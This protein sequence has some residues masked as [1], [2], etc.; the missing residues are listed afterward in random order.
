MDVRS[1]H[2]L[3]R[4]F[5]EV[6]KKMADSERFFTGR[7]AT[8][9]T[10]AAERYPSDQTVIQMAA[11]LAKRAQ[12][13]G[14]HLISRAELRDVYNKLHTTNTK[15]ASFLQDELGVNPNN[16]PEAKKM[17]RNAN[18]GESVRQEDFADPKLVA[19][20]ESAF[21]KNVG[22]K[23]GYDPR[24]GKVAEK[25]VVASLPGKPRVQVVDGR[26]YAVLCQASYD[27]P[28]GLATVLIPVEVVKSQPVP[29]NVFLSRAGFVNLN[30]ENL[31]QHLVS[32][33]GKYF[34]VNSAQLFDV[35]K[36]AKFGATEEL[37]SVDRAVLALKAKAGTPAT[38]DPNGILYQEVDKYR[39]MVKVPEH[40]D[41]PKFAERL[42]STAGE[43]EFVFGKQAVDTGRGMVQM[44][45]A[46]IGYRNAQIKVSNFNDDSIIYSVA[47]N[48]AGFKVPVKVVKQ[49]SGKYGV[50]IP[51][52][53]MAAGSVETLDNTGVKTAL[54][55][56]DQ[57]AFA[58]AVGLDLASSQQLL[59]E[60]E[61]ACDV[62][63]YKRA[64]EVVSILNDRGDETAFKYAFNLYMQALDGKQVKT[65]SAQPKMKT[66]KIG[67][68][69]VEAS[70]GL[71]V[72]KVYVDENGVVQP[73]YRKN[74]NKTD[75]VASGGFMHSKIIMGM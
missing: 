47:I 37:D 59:G 70:T 42:S 30:K 16:L 24:V 73:K 58:A 2:N 35:S 51:T 13:P 31:E 71:P 7:L 9:L 72:D 67:G 12:A 44:K 48:G 22:Y 50:K 62:G 53:L 61:K 8:R 19:A 63:D 75:D 21:D 69:V 46:D 43:A 36:R 15:V 41:A 17:T 45:L 27:T 68:N 3:K 60:V 28:K 64:G 65:A 18:E 34:R 20:L 26:E 11:F 52:M 74:M 14:G 32:T 66:I 54:G 40:K 56:H 25:L 10:K 39:E 57:G 4:F 49:A 55:M 6:S 33:A 1:I 29:P 38:H 5:D 23:P